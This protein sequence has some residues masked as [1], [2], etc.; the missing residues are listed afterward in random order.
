MEQRNPV[1][2]V[3]T[4]GA[5]SLAATVKDAFLPDRPPVDLF[6]S[7][8][9]SES[10]PESEDSDESARERTS[11]ADL[12]SGTA[13][14]ALPTEGRGAVP[15]GWYGKTAPHRGYGSESSQDSLGLGRIDPKLPTGNDHRKTQGQKGR[16]GDAGLSRDASDSEGDSDKGARHRS[17][18]S[19]KRNGN[20]RKRKHKRDKS[21]K[22]H[23]KH[24]HKRKKSS[25]KR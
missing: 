19:R 10:E 11:A 8:F 6:K 9:E 16:R 7:I 24:E 14:I 22:K 13:T 17:S 25:S 23:R 5:S 3:S 1:D 20:K 21:E 2:M 18:V 4:S 15:Q 12:G